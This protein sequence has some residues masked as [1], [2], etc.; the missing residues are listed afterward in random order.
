[1]QLFEKPRRKN[2]NVNKIIF[3]LGFVLSCYPVVSNKIVQKQQISLLSSYQDSIKKEDQT[4]R[5]KRI[6]DAQ[7]YNELLCDRQRYAGEQIEETRIE[8]YENQ[9]KNKDSD[10][11]GCVEIPKIDLRLPIY[12]GTSDEVLAQGVGHLEGTSLPIGGNDTHCVLTGHRGLPRAK[13]FVRLDE[14]KEGDFFFLESCGNKLSY[15]V[16]EIEVIAPQ[17]VEKLKISPG[18]D[19]VSLVTCTPYGINTKRLVVTG[20]REERKDKGKEMKTNVPSI[21]ECIFDILPFIFC[22]IAFLVVFKEGRR[23]IRGQKKNEN[24]YSD[25]F[26]SI[27]FWE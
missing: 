26:S 17:E 18:Q 5:S 27:T 13:L 21:R 10:I 1:M 20:E 6:K 4:L 22:L 3:L 9:L 7:A 2:K 15:Q 16:K 14:L 23:K 8:T 12:H 11:M 24:N 19:L 25:H